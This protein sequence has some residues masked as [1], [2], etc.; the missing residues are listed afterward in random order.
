MSHAAN[1]KSSQRA[2]EAS[3]KHLKI[4]QNR[5]RPSPDGVNGI[6]NNH[7][8]TKLFAAPLKDVKASKN[9]HP[10]PAGARIGHADGDVNVTQPSQNVEVISSDDSEEDDDEDEDS[11]D[12]EDEDAEKSRGESAM[13]MVNGVK[14]QDPERNPR[15]VG[16]A[17]RGD[18]QDHSNDAGRA[19]QEE[20]EPSF[21][22]LLRMHDGTMVD[23]TA[24]DDEMSGANNADGARNQRRGL[25]IP[26]ANSLGTVL[27][28]ALRTNDAPMLESCLQVVN[29]QN[30]RTTIERLPSQQA[31]ELLQRLAERMHKRPGRAGSL[32]VWIQWTVVAHGGYLAT[33]PSVMRQLQELHRVVRMRANALQPL[34]ALK[35][36][37][38][39][40]EA[41]LQLRKSRATY[42]Q[43]PQAGRGEGVIYIE[44]E[45][46]GDDSDDESVNEQDM[47]QQRA[48]SSSRPR[49]P[50][51]LTFETDV[52]ADD[53]PMINGVT[54]ASEEEEQSE[55]DDDDD[56]DD[57][58]DLIDD[59]AEPADSDEELSGE[60]I[61]FDEV[62]GEEASVSG[63]DNGPARKKTK[64]PRR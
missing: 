25:S 61:D 21:G 34:L 14:R 7:T 23:V 39:M 53:V 24:R 45:S 8:P 5:T 58:E 29:L 56:D 18:D 30:I 60:D 49:L 17:L 57:D 36:K 33:Q 35:G 52:E 50:R 20:A 59:E 41:Q 64:T 62:D 16:E 19:P 22:D 13:K 31:G 2:R 55:D 40:L 6:L 4:S 11:G 26:S 1:L 44:G 12:D 43:E 15:Q 9:K 42:D 63:E 27:S 54:E 46:S 47:S 3:S 28:Q 38:D 51:D 32:M 48:S 37:L 10:D